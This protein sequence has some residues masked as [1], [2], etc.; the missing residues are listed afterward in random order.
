[1]GACVALSRTVPTTD[2]TWQKLRLQPLE[3]ARRTNRTVTRQRTLM[4]PPENVTMDRRAPYEILE[5]RSLLYDIDEALAG[6]VVDAPEFTLGT[7]SPPQLAVCR[8][9]Q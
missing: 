9:P 1:M 6:R 7:T 5:L 2:A 4:H 3:I 8:H